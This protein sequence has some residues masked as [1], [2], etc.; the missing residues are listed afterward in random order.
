[1][2]M[3]TYDAVDRQI[4]AI[5]QASGRIANIDLAD[6]VSLSPSACLRRV[7]A[8][9]A[10]GLIAGY[11]AEIDREKLGLGLSVFIELKVERHS[12]DTSSQV[13][14]TLAAIP[15]VLACHVVSGAADF[16][17]EVAVP[18][19]RA[20]EQLLLD[21]ILAI[22]EV[23]DAHTTFA[24]RTVKTRAPL[25]L[26]MDH[27]DRQRT[28]H[29][30]LGDGQNTE[31]EC[32][33]LTLQGGLGADQRRTARHHEQQHDRGQLPHRL[34]AEPGHRLPERDGCHTE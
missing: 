21:Q 17:V 24:I 19:L 9:E 12:R 4:L 18:S 32:K 14:Q 3:T 5:L 15:A 2:R 33:G 26:D 23:V 28:R 16:L 22:P 8:L 10:D 30:G 1:M 20:Y 13:E 7:K 11:H 6:A 27:R 31:W 25:P 34:V 29:R